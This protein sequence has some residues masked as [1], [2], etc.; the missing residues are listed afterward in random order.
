MQHVFL[1]LSSMSRNY[2]LDIIMTNIDHGEKQ[3]RKKREEDI[4]IFWE[5]G[6]YIYGRQCLLPVLAWNINHPKNDLARNSCYLTFLL[7]LLTLLLFYKK[8]AEEKKMFK[9]LDGA[10]TNP[11][12][13][14]LSNVCLPAAS[15]RI[16]TMKCWHTRSVTTVYMHSSP[17]CDIVLNPPEPL[18][19]QRRHENTSTPFSA[20]ILFTKVSSLSVRSAHHGFSLTHI[21]VVSGCIADQYPPINPGTP[22]KLYGAIFPVRVSSYTPSAR[23]FDRSPR[24]WKRRST[25]CRT[26]SVIDKHR[27]RKRDI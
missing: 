12:F 6:I 20:W 25:E 9:R 14:L 19:M 5:E 27:Q 18:I 2:S 13:A 11:H 17:W 16:S 26:N 22:P 8:K 7:L 15:P 21:R 24:R 10:H 3:N 1:Y 4:N 23:S